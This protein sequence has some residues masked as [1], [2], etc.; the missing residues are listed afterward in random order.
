MIYVDNAATTRISDNVIEQMI[1][2]LK[3]HY[4]NASSQYSFGLA[5]KHAVDKARIQFASALNALPDEIVF[6]SGGSEGN[7]WVL[8]GVA[9]SLGNGHGHI[10][11]SSIEHHSILNACKAIEKRGVE[12]TYLPVDRYGRVSSV[13]VRKSIQKD[14]VLVSIM[15]ANNEIGTLQPISEIGQFLRRKRILFH[16]DAVQSLGKIPVDVNDLKVDLLTV[17]GHKI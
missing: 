16:T 6:T 15:L 5:A 9:A 12:V 14:T 7:N 2:F 11:T 10:I 3:E 17:S 13:D 4:G 8:F 1:P